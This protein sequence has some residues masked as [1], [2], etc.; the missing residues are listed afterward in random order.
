MLAEVMPGQ[1]PVPTNPSADPTAAR[2]LAEEVLAQPEY[3]NRTPKDSV[4]DK[5]LRA[6]GDLLER[7]FRPR[8]GG[9]GGLPDLTALGW[10]VLIVLVL[11][12]A[13][14]LWRVVRG[15]RRRA[16]PEDDEAVDIE[17]AVASTRP[18]HSWLDEAAEA[19]AAGRWKDGLRARFRALVAELIERDLVRSL[20]GRTVGEFRAEVR[21]GAPEVADTFAG[22]CRLFERAYYG[23]EPTG[24]AEAA[25]FAAAAERVVVSARAHAD[26]L[27]RRRLAE[28]ET[29]RTPFEAVPR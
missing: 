20:P 26:E 24:P 12:L 7:L 25:E 27:R 10:V 23:D 3:A 29:A 16:R 21:R 18:S 9:S 22:A 13:F 14:V 15:Y 17:V 6:L 4:L 19:E 1:P 5:I 11:V 2:R 8:S 28:A